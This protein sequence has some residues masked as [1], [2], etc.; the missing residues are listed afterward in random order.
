MTVKE[1]KKIVNKILKI[2]FLASLVATLRSGRIVSVY[3]DQDKDFI[4]KWKNDA[5]VTSRPSYNPKNNYPIDCFLYDFSPKP[6]DVILIVGAADGEEVP[7]FCKK[8]RIVIC[9]EPTP[10]CI[11]RLTKLKNIL[12]LSNLILINS[13]AGKLSTKVKFSINEE[14]DLHNRF[15]TENIE[16]KGNE[17][18]VKVETLTSILKNL[19]INNIDYC[20]INIEG[21]EKNALLGLDLEQIKIKKF[22]ISAHD[23]MGPSTRTYD[24]V[25]NWLIENNY[26]VKKYLPESLDEYY[27]N[28][29]LYGTFKYSDY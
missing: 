23:F 18:L 10:N 16:S 21:E 29:Y 28:Y 24:W 11:R 9:V 17:I 1:L 19:D 6:N 27:K 4:Y 12:K 25:F 15:S 3:Q 2:P 13:A 14:N 5:A 7:Y 8:S 26:D 22:C 20:K